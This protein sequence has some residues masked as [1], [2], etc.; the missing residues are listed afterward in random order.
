[1]N[2]NVQTTVFIYL[3]LSFVSYIVYALD[4]SAAR[5]S[6]WRIP[7]N[8]LHILA[9]A[10]GWPGALLAQSVLRH[11]T[12]KRS[13]RIVFWLTVVLN[14]AALQLLFRKL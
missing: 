6:A 8:T 1:M 4:K 5:R 2:L 9:L 13:F 12:I 11:K 10:G 14:L 7:E 3:G